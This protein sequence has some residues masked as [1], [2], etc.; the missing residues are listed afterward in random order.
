FMAVRRGKNSDLLYVNP[1]RCILCSR[2][3]KVNVVLGRFLRQNTIK[4]ALDAGCVSASFFSS[5]TTSL[6]SIIMFISY[7]VTIYSQQGYLLLMPYQGQ[8]LFLMR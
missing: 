7:L 3:I 5:S 6:L 2:P 1:S 4:A 8:V